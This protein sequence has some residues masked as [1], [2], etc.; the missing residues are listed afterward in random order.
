VKKWACYGLAVFMTI[1][2]LNH[3]LTPWTYEQMVPRELGHAQLLVQ[4]SGV[5]EMAGGLGLLWPKTR[6]LAAYGLIALFL[7]VF[8]ANINMAVNH[9]ALGTKH[10][11]AWTLW[12][13]LPLQ[14]VFIAWAWWVRGYGAP[15]SRSQPST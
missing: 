13:R 11:P 14:L 7:A 4:L 9:L 8:P 15:A 10:V 2:G 1:A 3:F 5:A 6:R 12:A